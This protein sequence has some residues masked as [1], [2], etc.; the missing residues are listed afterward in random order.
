MG[1]Q[2][3]SIVLM[4][5]LEALLLVAGLCAGADD[6]TGVI[7]LPSDTASGESVR[8]RR[9]PRDDKIRP[10]ECCDRQ[11]CTKSIP[12]ICWCHDTLERCS[13]ACKECHKARGEGP[14]LRYICKDRYIGDPAPRCH[15][16]P[17]GNRVII[18]HD[19]PKE[20]AVVRG[21]K[22]GENGQDPGPSYTTHA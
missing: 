14:P 10:W 6:D 8:A 21:S 16:D 11:I 7:R 20:M 2:V 17:Y 5:S 1:K 12:A 4:L 18:V 9:M 13:D 19:G 22:K 15:D 3:A